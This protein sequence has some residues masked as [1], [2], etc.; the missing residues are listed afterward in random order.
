MTLE[1]LTQF[2]A[3]VVASVLGTAVLLFVLVRLFQ[4]S[5]GGRLS[6]AVRQLRDREQAAR[7]ARKA[8][9]KAAAKFD[10]LRAKGDAAIPRQVEA[11]REALEETQ[12]IQKLVDDQVLVARNEVRI[13]IL[14]EYPEKRHAAMRYK[15]LAE[16]T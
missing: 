15:Y 13:L 11:A 2:W 4:D 5:A 12:E 16:R 8:V 3:L 14:E 7:A 6:A 1:Y 10:R 9:D